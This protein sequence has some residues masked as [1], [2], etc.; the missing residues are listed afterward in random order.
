VLVYD[1]ARWLFACRL[2]ER[3]RRRN[4]P[5]GWRSVRACSAADEPEAIRLGTASGAAHGGNCSSKSEK[6]RSARKLTAR[7]N[8]AFRG[9]HT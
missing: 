4:T 9:M 8:A 7:V 2:H 3:E 1:A 6:F 5:L